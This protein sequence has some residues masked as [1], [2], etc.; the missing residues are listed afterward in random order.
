[1]TE[2][3][4][5]VLVAD[6]ERFFR[7]AIRDALAE[8]GIE[9]R[10]VAGGE[11]ALGAADDPAVG[12]VV[13]DL[14]LSEPGGLEVLEQLSSR[15]PELRVIA[16][17]TATDQDLVL[18]ALRVHA[19]DYLAKPLHEEAG[20]TGGATHRARAERRAPRRVARG[21]GGGGGRRR[22]GRDEGVADVARRAR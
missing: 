10:T 9:C 22:A 12:V 13:L 3:K 16:L 14:Q 20:G 7:E 2:P 18:E 4:P 8:A 19:C 1:M 15:R 5:G 11:E 6:R 17:S 21:A